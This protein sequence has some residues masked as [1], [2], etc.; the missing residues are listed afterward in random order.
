MASAPPSFRSIKQRLQ[1]G[2]PV[3]VFCVGR[4]IHP[5]IFDL[6]GM[7][8]GFHGCW[9]DQE[10]A[11][12]TYEQIVLASACCRAQGMDSFVRMPMT[13]YAQA[14]A[15]LEAGTGGLMA[16]RIDTAAEAETFVSWAKFAPRGRRGLNTS[17]F[18]ADYGALSLAELAQRA[19]ERN[20]VAIQIE[21]EGALAE[22]EAIAAIQ[23]V[24]MLFVGP[25]DLSQELGVIG[26]WE[27]EKLWSAYE[28]VA[29]ACQQHKKS[30]GTIAV[31]PTFARRVQ[32][33][34]CQLLSFGMDAIIY[35]RGIEGTKR[36]F[37]G[38]FEA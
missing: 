27:S 24:D 1:A 23:D 17:G 29:A 13:G 6:H 18:D 8:G 25:S 11:A 19:N 10:H 32:S 9:I 31:N 2:E 14:T 28:R 33:L 37:E 16:A 7:L 21:T 12:T 22:C 26:N 5:V 15:N 34:G 38:F 4:L 36:S 20:L 3:N 35:R 30:W